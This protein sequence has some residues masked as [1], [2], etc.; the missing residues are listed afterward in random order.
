MDRIE[1][2]F[3]KLRMGLS[4]EQAELLCGRLAGL[5]P[6]RIIGPLAGRD[7]AV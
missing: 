7:L 2:R 3:E 5:L 4:A 6:E 1:G